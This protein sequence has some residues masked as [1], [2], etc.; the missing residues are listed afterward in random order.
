MPQKW[1]EARADK[2]HEKDRNTEGMQVVI[3]FKDC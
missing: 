3:G 1:E 2:M